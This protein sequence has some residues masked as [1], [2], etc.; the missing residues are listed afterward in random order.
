[1]K[2]KNV[3]Q[4]TKIG[5]RSNWRNINS[6]IKFENYVICLNIGKILEDSE[7]INSSNIR[8]RFPKYMKESHHKDQ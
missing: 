3:F 2:S 8:D 1:M 4:G 5:D 6:E 7:H